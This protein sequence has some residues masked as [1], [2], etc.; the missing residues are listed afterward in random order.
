VIVEAP[1]GAAGDGVAEGR[2]DGGGVE[3]GV[4][5]E[6]LVLGAR[7]RVEDDVGDL[8]ELEDAAVLGAERRQ[9]D[10]AGAVV[11]DRLLVKSMF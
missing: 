4:G 6:R 9:L 1:R 7:R 8:R 10:R 3:A 11:Q 2:Q 5:P